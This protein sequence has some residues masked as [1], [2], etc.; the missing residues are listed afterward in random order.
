MSGAKNLWKGLKV[1]IFLKILIIFISIV[2]VR[3]VQKKVQVKLYLLPTIRAVEIAEFMCKYVD[4][5]SQNLETL[6]SY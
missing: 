5:I 1:E 2:N 3:V 6:S 4:G